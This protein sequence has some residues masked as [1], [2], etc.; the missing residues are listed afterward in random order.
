MIFSSITRAHQKNIGG[1][2]RLPTINRIMLWHLSANFARSVIHRKRRNP[3]HPLV[4]PSLQ[5]IPQFS[6]IY[7]SQ[8]TN[9]LCLSHLN[10]KCASNSMIS[11][12]FSQSE[13]IIYTHASTLLSHKHSLPFPLFETSPGFRSRPTWWAKSTPLTESWTSNA[14]H[15]FRFSSIGFPVTRELTEHIPP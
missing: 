3:P 10:K 2:L 7:P 9:S 5:S 13:I 11:P 15:S 8:S 6:W 1:S 14:R 12:V 4:F